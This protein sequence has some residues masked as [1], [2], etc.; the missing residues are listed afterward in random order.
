MGEGMEFEG[1]KCGVSRDYIG[2]IFKSN[3]DD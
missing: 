1:L 2:Y 3:E